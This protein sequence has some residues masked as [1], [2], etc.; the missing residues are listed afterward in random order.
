MEKT[1]NYTEKLSAVAISMV[2]FLL[3]GITSSLIKYFYDDTYSVFA[4]GV[5]IFIF[6]YTI[7]NTKNI[8]TDYLIKLENSRSTA[9]HIMFAVISMAIGII[10][11]YRYIFEHGVYYIVIMIAI[12]F[13][14]SLTSY[15]I[16]TYNNSIR[17][18]IFEKVN[19]KNE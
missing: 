16:I 13:F 17:K 3:V 15:N 2:Y 5:C 8:S 1:L 18:I 14:V 4:L 9:L 6:V 10:E 7:F 19:S 11:L 12:V